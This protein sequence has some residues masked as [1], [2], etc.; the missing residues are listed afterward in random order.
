MVENNEQGTFWPQ[1]SEYSNTS[2]LV[3]MI[4]EAHG[5]K[6]R[7]VKGFGWALKLMSKVTGLVNKAFG[8]LQYSSDLS[9]YKEDYT[10][11]NLENS[12]KETEKI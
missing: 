1:N 4:A 10:A 9:A 7:L 11:V 12:I 3:K 5:K 6:V 8:N 2:E